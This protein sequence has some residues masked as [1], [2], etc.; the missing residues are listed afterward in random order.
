MATAQ[1]EK[2][3]YRK[4]ARWVQRKRAPASVSVLSHYAHL[5]KKA[6]SGPKVDLTDMTKEEFLAFIRR[7]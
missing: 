1:R 6:D 7:G 5:A 3:Q 2:T 4:I